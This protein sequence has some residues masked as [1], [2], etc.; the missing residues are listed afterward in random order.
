M[1][2]R[3]KPDIRRN[4]PAARYG[5]SPYVTRTFRSE[6]LHDPGL[7]VALRLPLVGPADFRAWSISPTVTRG[8]APTLKLIR[9]RGSCYGDLNRP[10]CASQ[11]EHLHFYSAT[12]W[13]ARPLRSHIPGAFVVLWKICSRIRRWQIDQSFTSGLSTNR[14]H[15]RKALNRLLDSQNSPSLLNQHRLWLPPCLSR[16]CP[17]PQS[18]RVCPYLKRRCLHLE[19]YLQQL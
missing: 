11:A 18:L 9:R 10:E 8:S 12:E 13:N 16:Q 6:Y 5:G 3:F 7:I 2:N 4:F 19:I 15:R 14:R 1:P 17:L